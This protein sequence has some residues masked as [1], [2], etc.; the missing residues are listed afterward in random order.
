MRKET[1]ELRK[2]LGLA[3]ELDGGVELSDGSVE[4]END[5]EAADA[6]ERELGSG[7]LVH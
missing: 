1:L 6:A 3:K 4:L 7:V 5:S 2:G